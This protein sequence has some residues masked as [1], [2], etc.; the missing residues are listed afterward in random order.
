MNNILALDGSVD[1]CSVALMIGQ[2]VTERYESTARQ[3][4]NFLLPM[5]DSLLS[6]V[7]LDLQ[8]LDAIA[9]ACGPGNFTGVRIA[10][11]IAQGLAFAANLPVVMVSTLQALAQ[12]AYK[13]YGATKV[14]VALDARMQQIYWGAYSLGAD[15]LMQ[16]L[17]EDQLCAPNQVTAPSSI[18]KDWVMVGNALSEYSEVLQPFCQ[19][20]NHQYPLLTSPNARD[21][22]MIAQVY[23]SQGRAVSP[24][25]ALPVYLRDQNAWKK[26]A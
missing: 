11:S 25:L 5:V 15:G 14:L 9:V 13:N 8:Q 6:E 4:A 18:D 12:G 10:V 24:E 16:A 26:Q 22:A 2:Q 17:Q 20:L 7:A 3:H 23:F 19:L 21:V 1:A